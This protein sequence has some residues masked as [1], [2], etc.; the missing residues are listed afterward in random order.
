MSLT[1][2]N[3]PVVLA[4]SVLDPSGASGLQADIETAASL[5][6]HCAPVLTAMCA[7]GDVPYTETMVVD[8]TML[9]EQARS[10]LACMD[11]KAVK[12]G[13]LGSRAIAEAVHSI[14][15]DYTSIP[16]VSHPA[17]CLLDVATQE[18][19]DL[20]EAYADLILPLSMVANFSLFEAQEVAKERDTID[21]TA[22]SLISKGCELAL[23]T[24]TGR[25]PQAFQNSTF[26]NKGLVKNYLWQQEPPICHGASTT[27]ATGMASY[28]AHGFEP[29]QAMEQAQNFT[30]HAMQASRNMGFNNRT[31]HR[32]FWADKNIETS[33][34]SPPASQTN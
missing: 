21:T 20:I 4:F 2:A 15:I 9:I 11:V 31:P 18:Y 26:S 12:V 19:K 13:F 10:V 34:D 22:H 3:P 29:S 5:G 6:C 32:F 27:L 1:S 17:L 16:V 30:W 8:P 33:T 25:Q 14:L 24:G 23:I 28:L 7:T